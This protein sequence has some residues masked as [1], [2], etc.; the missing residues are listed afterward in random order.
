MKKIDISLVKK[1]INGEDLGEFTSEQLEN[2]KD[3]M[4]GVISYTNDP[5]MYSFCSESVKQNYEFVKYLVLK[6]KDNSEFIT[7]IADNYLDNTD[8][9]WERRELNIIMEKVL[10]KELAEKYEMINETLYFEKRLEVEIAE[11]KDSKLES[12]IGMGFWLMFDQYNVMG[13]IEEMAVFEKEKYQKNPTG[14][15]ALMIALNYK[16]SEKSEKE[17]MVFELDDNSKVHFYYDKD[18]NEIEILKTEGR[19]SNLTTDELESKIR[20]FQNNALERITE[21]LGT[22]EEFLNLSN[23]DC[24]EKMSEKDYQKET[25]SSLKQTLINQKQ[26]ILS[27]QTTEK[28][29]TKTLKK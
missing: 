20:N 12:M 22:K 29:K 16:M 9:D 7:A 21:I 28:E 17:I 1:Y 27:N 2:D 8:T 15:N 13:C 23:S 19:A 26:E 11:A 25:L 10:P 24:D 14:L 5:K 3:F 6:F 18:T 4:M